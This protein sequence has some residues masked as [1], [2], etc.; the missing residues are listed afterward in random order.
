MESGNEENC[1][2]KCRRTEGNLCNILKTHKRM[3]EHA[4]AAAA[5]DNNNNNNNNKDTVQTGSSYCNRP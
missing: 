1:D 2:F 3:R 4:A 5:A